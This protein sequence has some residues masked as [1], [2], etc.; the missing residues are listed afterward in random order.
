MSYGHYGDFDPDNEPIPTQEE[1]ELPL[2]PDD[3][4]GSNE[5]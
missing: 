2:E 4:Q 5:D 1:E 3:G